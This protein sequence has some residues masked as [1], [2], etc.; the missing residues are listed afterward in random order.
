MSGR[1]VRRRETAELAGGFVYVPGAVPD[2]DGRQ[3]LQPLGVAG[4][5]AHLTLV[6]PGN[7]PV[8]VP[9]VNQGNL[10]TGPLTPY[11]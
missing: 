10:F 1:R 9:P 5:V 11:A 3:G 4:E 2:G 8:A 6:P 7:Q